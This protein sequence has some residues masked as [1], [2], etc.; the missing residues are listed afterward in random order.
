M[1]PENIIQIIV[2]RQSKSIWI[3]VYGE[4]NMDQILDEYAEALQVD[5]TDLR[6]LFINKRANKSTM[7]R[8]ATVNNLCL[9]NGDEL[10]IR[11][12]TSV[13]NATMGFH[14]MVVYNT[15]HRLKKNAM[16]EN[17]RDYHEMYVAAS[18]NSGH[19]IKFYI[20]DSTLRDIVTFFVD[21]RR[22]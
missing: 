13:P 21:A 20:S 22:L 2:K 17:K 10:L 3:E 11:D 1:T 14:F 6:I 9:Q 5:L 12:R 15:L 7:D 19:E 16:P 4:N 8:Y 18:T